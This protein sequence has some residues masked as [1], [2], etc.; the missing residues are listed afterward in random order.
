MEFTPVGSRSQVVSPMAQYWGQFC[1]ISLSMIWTR[2]SISLQATPSCAG[3]VD[4][5]EGRKVLQ[6]DLDSLDPWAKVNCMRFNKAKCWVLYLGHSNPMQCYRLGEEWLESCLAEKD[7][8]V[9]VDSQLNMSQRCAQVAK[10][11]NSIL[12]CIKNSVASRMREVIVSLYS[13]LV[14]PHLEYCVQFWALHYKRDIEVLEC[15]Q[16]RAVKL[17]KGLEHKSS[18]EQLRE[19]VFLEKRRRSGDLI[20]VYNYLKGSCREVGVGLFSQLISDRMRG[21]GLKLCQGRFRLD[22]RKNLFTERFIKHWNRLPREVV[23]SPTLEVFKRCVDAVLRDMVDLAV[24]AFPEQTR[25]IQIEWVV[26]EVDR[27]LASRSHLEDGNQWLLLRLATCHKW[28]PPGIDTVQ[29]VT[30]FNVFINDLDDGIESTLTKFAGDTRLG[31]EVNTS[32]ARAILQRT[33]A[34]W[35]S[36]LARTARC[37]WLRSS[38]AERDLGVLVDNKLTMSQQYA[39]TATK[40]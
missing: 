34:G 19:L 11:A 6:R 26:Y 8:G 27:K 38:L 18:E 10:K 36:E 37:V 22:I 33:W 9:L 16:R 21:N 24:L 7:L 25:K 12:A 35:K 32:E 28:G 3:V 29:R 4:L 5:L 30:L 23:E 1:L 17:V 15:F 20:A 13:A 40:A 31:V 39:A 2:G 14:R